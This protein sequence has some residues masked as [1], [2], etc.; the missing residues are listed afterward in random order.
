MADVAKIQQIREHFGRLIGARI[1]HFVT[2]ESLAEDGTWYH[3]PDLPIRIYTENGRMAAAA[4]SRSDDLWLA[5]DDS[6]PF[7]IE[8]ARTR[9][10]TNNISM[11]NE[12][13]GQTIGA[14]SLG[15]DDLGGFRLWTRLLLTLDKV[16]LEVRNAGDENGYV[17]HRAEPTGEFVNCV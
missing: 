8:D 1:T 16:W 9:W 11:L 7:P 10:V 2:A 4:W 5:N 13:C 17:L 6:L 12:C 3:W 14:V 15:A